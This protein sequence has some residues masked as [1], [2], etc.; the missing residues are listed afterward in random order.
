MEVLSDCMGHV[1]V[2]SRRRYKKLK[3]SAVNILRFTLVVSVS[4]ARISVDLTSLWCWVPPSQNNHPLIA[5]HDDLH[6][7]MHRMIA[8]TPLTMVIL[9]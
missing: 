3:L 7:S 5:H 2:F 4:D 1:F 8:L 9:T 6:K